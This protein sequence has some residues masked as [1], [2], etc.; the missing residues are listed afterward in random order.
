MQITAH[1]LVAGHV[2]SRVAPWAPV[3]GLE[4]T[5]RRAA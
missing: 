3:V 4:L 1:A 2:W 5:G